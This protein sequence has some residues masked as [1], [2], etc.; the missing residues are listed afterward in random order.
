MGKLSNA[1]IADIA[2]IIGEFYTHAQINSS[3]VRSGAPGEPPEGSKIV[4]TTAWLRR[5]NEDPGCDEIAVLGG[6]LEELMDR[7][8][9]LWNQEHIAKMRSHV[10]SGLGRH[11]LSYRKGGSI[12]GATLSTPSRSL[13][14]LIRGRQLAEVEREFNRALENVESDP[15]AALTAACAILEALF[16]VIIADESLK[17]PSEQSV[18]PLWKVV[19]GHLGLEPGKTTDPDDRKML[20][21]F[22]TAID[23][24][25]GRRTKTSSAHGRGPGAAVV[26]PRHARLAVHAA[27]TVVTFIME[28]R[29]GGRTGTGR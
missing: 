1:L 2:A 6:V 8:F 24:I 26:E 7:E 18:L 21:G 23:G 25:A 5:A 4:K 3:F 10:T 27:H 19:Q 29:A 12:W 28:S 9:P 17:L 11:G 20:Q 22:L 16:K 15:P 13:E 14:D